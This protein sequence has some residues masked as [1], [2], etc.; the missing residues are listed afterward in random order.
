MAKGAYIGVS[1]KARKIKKMYFGVGG[2]A[3][4]VKK[5]YIGVGGVA[6]QFFSSEPT[7]SYWGAATPLHTARYY[8]AG[9]SVKNFA[10]FAGG[11]IDDETNTSAVDAYNGSL[12]HST[13]TSLSAE[14][15]GTTGVSGDSYAIFGGGGTTTRR[16]DILNAYNASLVRSI[17]TKLSEARG[18]ST[19]ERV[20][21][22]ALFCGGYT[23]NSVV[24]TVDA[25]NNSLVRSN[26]TSLSAAKES[27]AGARTGN[28]A[29]IAGGFDSRG[30]VINNA[31]VNSYNA[32]LVR[33]VPSALSVAR[34]GLAGASVDVFAL[35]AGGWADSGMVSTVEAYNSSLT[36]STI[37]SLS[38][39][40]RPKGCA[41]PSFAIFSSDDSYAFD[42]YNALLIRTS[43]NA[44]PRDN[45]ALAAVN[46]YCL[47]GG[48]NHNYT[49]SASVDVYQEV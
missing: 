7:V 4:K 39:S 3:R 27:A 22:Y 8:L 13:P 17:P 29:L 14:I 47:L 31:N 45:H 24:S 2:K 21:N 19:G 38:I 49:P 28:Y 30:L 16:T 37:A 5:G 6:R 18:G 41:T 46:N 10:L 23:G 44:S 11:S 25:Y 26:P 48:G 20:G 43:V 35:F 34:G 1:G 42:I 12:A 40:Y 32:S 15:G 9:A 36:R 33:G